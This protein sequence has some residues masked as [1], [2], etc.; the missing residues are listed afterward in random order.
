VAHAADIVND[1]EQPIAALDIGRRMDGN[2]YRAR[3]A[4]CPVLTTASSPTSWI[5]Q[6]DG[7]RSPIYSDNHHLTDK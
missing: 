5:W 1:D 3:G 4:S 6:T 2:G 7:R